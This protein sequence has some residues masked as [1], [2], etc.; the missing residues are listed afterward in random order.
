[1]NKK[2]SI[3]SATVTSELIIMYV[4]A[5]EAFLRHALFCHVYHRGVRFMPTEAKMA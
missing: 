5:Y 4:D 3:S 2:F 1:M